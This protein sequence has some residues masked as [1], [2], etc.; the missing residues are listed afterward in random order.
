MKFRYKNRKQNKK[1][2]AIIEL[3]IVVMI[4]SILIG[5]ATA[6]YSYFRQ[7]S[8]VSEAYINLAK[9]RACEETYRAENDVYLPCAASPP[10][11]GTDSAPDSWFDVSGGFTA[12]GFEPNGPVRYQYEVIAANT[13]YTAT[14]TGDLN[15]NDIQVVFS[16]T[17]S[18]PHQVKTTPPGEL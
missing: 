9:I 3:M 18:Q 1:G 8:R 11:G 5:I 17:D 16:V 12:I 6:I 7:Y 15:E 13:T 14:A 2:F 10:G 4:L